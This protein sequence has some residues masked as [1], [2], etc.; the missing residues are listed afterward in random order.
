MKLFLVSLGVGLVL[1]LGIGLLLTSTTPVHGGPQEVQHQTLPNGITY[2]LFYVQG[3]P[4]M[5]F[6]R[7]VGNNVWNYD[8]VSC[9]W[10]KWN[11]K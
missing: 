2:D 4:C 6:G 7:S 10:S 11:G 3:M 8:G 5:R 1:A 9:D